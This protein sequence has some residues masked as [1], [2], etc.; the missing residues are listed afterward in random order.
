[1]KRKNT[2]NLGL[3]ILVMVEGISVLP[4]HHSVLKMPF[5]ILTFELIDHL[6]AT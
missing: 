6:A 4:H 2:R 5:S 3:L 1:M